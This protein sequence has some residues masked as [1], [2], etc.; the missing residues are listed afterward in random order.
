[1]QTCEKRIS[2]PPSPPDTCSW[3]RDFHTQSQIITLLILIANMRMQ[4]H[5]AG[6]KGDYQMG[7]QFL[8]RPDSLT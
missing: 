2:L 8:R 1:M 6:I 7:K 5:A 3:E 4:N